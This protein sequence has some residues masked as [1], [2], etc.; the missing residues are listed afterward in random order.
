LVRI[1][2]DAERHHELADR[3]Q[4]D[5]RI[6]ESKPGG[7]DQEA[8]A[9]RHEQGEQSGGHDNLKDHHE[10]QAGDA[11]TEQPLGTDD[12]LRGFPASPGVMRAPTATTGAPKGA[13]TT[14]IA[15]ASPG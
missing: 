8:G 6:G 10:D 2:Q 9:H 5:R 15:R 14:I 7:H 4:V 1:A 12:V 13:K 3:R 11:A